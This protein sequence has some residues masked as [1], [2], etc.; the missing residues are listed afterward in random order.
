MFG[1][2]H[3]K[4]VLLCLFC[5]CY[6][7][8][9]D[10]YYSNSVFICRV[11]VK[12]CNTDKHG[13]TVKTCLVNYTQRKFYCAYFVAATKTLW[14]NIIVIQF[15]S[16]GFIKSMQSSILIYLFGSLIW[17][18]CHKSLHNSLDT[19]SS[20]ITLQSESIQSESTNLTYHH[21]SM[22]STRRGP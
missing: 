20:S 3:P 5:C 15:L 11:S 8:L 22:H 19:L 9:M 18:F 16:V 10:Q 13:S 6:Q 1:K 12:L 21:V 4:K 2:L 14:T 7:D 17:Q